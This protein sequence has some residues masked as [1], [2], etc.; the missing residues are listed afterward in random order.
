MTDLAARL[1]ALREQ[2][3]GVTGHVPVL[4]DQKNALV[5]V[6]EAVEAYYAFTRKPVPQGFNN[7]YNQEGIRGGAAMKSALDAL[8]AALSEAAR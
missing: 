1:A 4:L 8:D 2:E 3:A 7:A 6:A 5:A